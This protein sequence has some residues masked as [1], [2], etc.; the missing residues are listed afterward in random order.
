MLVKVWHVE[1]R[2]DK[3]RISLQA[4]ARREK[5]PLG[6]VSELWLEQNT[7]LWPWPVTC[8]S[9][10]SP[11]LA[12]AAHGKAAA[13]PVVGTVTVLLLENLEK[14]DHLRKMY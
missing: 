6:S 5:G 12:G 11:T 8:A 10:V 9:G 1:H 4:R 2:P 13:E 14:R 7:T 3:L